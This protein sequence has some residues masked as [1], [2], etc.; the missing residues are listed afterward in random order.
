MLI[1]QKDQLIA[2]GD[3]FGEVIG[4]LFK[5][6]SLAERYNDE[7]AQPNWDKSSKEYRK[8]LVQLSGARSDK[9]LAIG[10]LI[11]AQKSQETRHVDDQTIQLMESWRATVTRLE[12]AMGSRERCLVAR[13]GL[14]PGPWGRVRLAQRYVNERYYPRRFL[15]HFADLNTSLCSTC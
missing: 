15:R 12:A 13:D 14:D 5:L 9:W 6:S 2:N 11:A 1:T 4:K 7:A 3:E 10:A 8:V